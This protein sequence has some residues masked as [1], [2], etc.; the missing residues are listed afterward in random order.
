MQDSCAF[1][2]GD[3]GNP[4][5]MIFK[6]PGSVEV[7]EGR[8][9]ADVTGRNLMHLLCL[10]KKFRIGK[11]YSDY[12]NYHAL[13]ILNASPRPVFLGSERLLNATKIDWNAITEC[14]RKS[15]RAVLRDPVKT[16]VICCGHNAEDFYKKCMRDLHVDDRT[17]ITICHLGMKGMNKTISLAK[18]N[19]VSPT[20]QRLVTIAEY[21]DFSA[22]KGGYNTWDDFALY[23][24]KHPRHKIDESFFKKKMDDYL[25]RLEGA[26]K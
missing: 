2:K 18:D 9:V 14:W 5:L 16:F 13:T 20:Y 17:V 11:Q 6:E 4:I 19:V 8:P 23:L 1:Q 3:E 10:L 26:C 22:G 21:I 25:I 7:A 15:A 12:L 24:K